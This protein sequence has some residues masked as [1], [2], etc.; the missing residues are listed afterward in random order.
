HHPVELRRP[1]LTLLGPLVLQLLLG[2]LLR[3]HRR[4]HHWTRHVISSGPTG[5]CRYVP[6]L[7]G[8][9]FSPRAPRP[10]PTSASALR[11]PARAGATPSSSTARSPT[12][13]PPASSP[14]SSSPPAACALSPATAPSPPAP[15]SSA[16]P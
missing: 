12:P 11:S 16:A 8:R 9:V 13:P 5:P 10:R 7:L 4:A 15:A 14:G 6:P 1:R 2:D 3:R